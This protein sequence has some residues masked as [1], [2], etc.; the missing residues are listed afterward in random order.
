MKITDQSWLSKLL[1]VHRRGATSY[2]APSN[3]V[4]RAASGYC[5]LV[6][7]DLYRLYLLDER[8]P[9]LCCVPEL[10]ARLLNDGDSVR[11]IADHRKII[12]HA[13]GA[14]SKPGAIPRGRDAS[15][16]AIREWFAGREVEILADLAAASR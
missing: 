6:D 4:L 10:Q 16:D 12:T 2:G 3:G 15:P 8:L 11:A 9:W 1:S 5:L 14:S 7:A 13:G